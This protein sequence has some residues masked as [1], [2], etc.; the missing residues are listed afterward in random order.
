MKPYA[1]LTTAMALFTGSFASLSAQDQ[2][3]TAWEWSNLTGADTGNVFSANVSDQVAGDGEALD[4]PTGTMFANGQFGSDLIDNSAAFTFAAFTPSSAFNNDV[5]TDSRP[6]PNDLGGSGIDNAPA[7]LS[8]SDGSFGIGGGADPSGKHIVF[9]ASAI[10]GAQFDSAIRFTSAIGATTSMQVDFDYSYDGTNYTGLPSFNVTSLDQQ[11]PAF[12]FA[13]APGNT[14]LY[15]RLL[16]PTL[17]FEAL[18]VDNLQF[19]G[20]LVPEPATIASVL[21]LLAFGMVVYRR[22]KK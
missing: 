7:R 14:D 12:T 2:L 22:R 20:A 3:I 18:Y 11:G 8:I 17:G 19:V 9:V 10:N 1:K 5:V 21:G 13:D 15:L 6:A 4:G 16:V